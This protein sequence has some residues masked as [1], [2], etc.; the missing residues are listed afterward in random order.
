M[1]SYTGKAQPLPEYIHE[2]SSFLFDSLAIHTITVFTRDE[3]QVPK[4]ARDS[5]MST[6]RARIGQRNENPK[7]NASCALLSKGWIEF[8][9]SGAFG[10]DILVQVA[11]W[12][13]IP[14]SKEVGTRK[15]KCHELYGFK[16]GNGGRK[17][18]LVLCGFG[19]PPAG[20]SGLL[21]LVYTW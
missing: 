12:V 19:R 7:L 13:E 14:I 10:K 5:E 2:R 3:I 18:F 15:D 16:F 1:A 9:P 8:N 6:I 11:L 17:E 20:P 4:M 21:I